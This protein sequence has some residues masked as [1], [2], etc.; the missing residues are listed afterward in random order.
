VR[1]VRERFRRDSYNLVV[2]LAFGRIPNFE[3][4]VASA[5]DEKVGC[6]VVVHAKD[7]AFM[8]A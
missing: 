5:R 7:I 6:L 2:S 1:A 8:S 3:V 4:S